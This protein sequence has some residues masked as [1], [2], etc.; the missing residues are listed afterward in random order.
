MPTEIRIYY[1]GD[2]QL[3]PGFD[4]FLS[5][6][7]DRARARRCRFRLISVKGTPVQD[8]GIALRTHMDAWNILLKDS[9][10]PDSGNLSVALCTDHGLSAE[11]AAS[12]FWMVEMMESWFHADKDAL[13]PFYGPGFLRNALKPN[14]QVE[15]IPKKDLVAGL[16]AATR[17]TIKG[18]YHKTGHA[19]QLLARIDP[20]LVRDAAPN[21]RKLFDAILAQLA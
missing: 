10:G 8:F 18:A 6:I 5:E 21:C 1:E 14:L 20:A 16:K 4:A 17:K 15:K 11:H 3:K 7:R 13:E 9:E 12:I 2:A 19:A